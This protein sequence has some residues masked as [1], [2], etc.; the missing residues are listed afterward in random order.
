VSVGAATRESTTATHVARRIG[1]WAGFT[2]SFFSI[3]GVASASG[4]YNPTSFGWTALALS[5]VVIVAVALRAPTWRRLDIAWSGL[6]A[7]FCVFL[8]ASAGWAASAD[9]AVNDALRCVVYVVGI[10]AALV[11]L[12]RSTEHW[13][14]GLALGA[15]SVCV[16]ALAT[17]LF[18]GRFG[19]FN[20][21]STYRLFVPLGYW[22]A[23]GC[24]AAIASLI[25]LGIGVLGRE[26]PLRIAAAVSLVP[27]IATLYFTF[28]RGAWGSL[29]VGVAATFAVSPL[30]LRLLGGAAALIP[31]PA[32]GVLIASRSS[33]LTHHLVPLGAA[34]HAG[35]K[36]A[37]ELA[38][39]GVG[40]LLVAWAFVSFS[41]RVEL[42]PQLR[43]LL[44]AVVLLVIVASVIAVFTR[45]G[46]PETLATRSY[47]SFAKS[48][49]DTGSLNG[50]LFTLSNN[51][52]IVL[53]HAAVAD[54][55]AHPIIGSGAGS[56]G[57]WWLAHRTSDYFVLDA[58]ELYLQT[59]AEDGVVGLGL[60]IA[61]LAVPFV[62]G[63]RARR[64]PLVAPAVGA[65]VA[66]LAHATVDWDWQM[67]AVTLLVFFV[68]AAL[69]AASRTPT[70]QPSPASGR[71]RIAIGVAAAV[72][73]VIAFVG[74]I[75]N[76]ALARSEDDLLNAEP[77][78]AL[79]QA[80][81]AHRWAPW[82][83][84]ALRDLGESRLLVGQRGAGLSDL[85]RAA[86]KDPSDWETWLDIAA[87][88]TGAERRAA[89]ARAHALNPADPAVTA[90]ARGGPPP[91]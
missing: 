2:V 70:L 79:A 11:V 20:A 56:F 5:W 27:L 44:G 54:F 42:S 67:P 87:A 28:S 35:H 78:A 72:V 17:K 12:R 3:V 30:R 45:Y 83:A 1:P 88:G 40:Q 80:R 68:G 52:R 62:A 66:Y 75:G 89:L 86:T 77:A 29:A 24:F 7:A 51:N 37:L 39:L 23:L 8:F 4:G 34:A 59:L 31:L 16:Y 13:L 18:P 60:L 41:R 91:P 74:L 38:L 69:V 14:A 76:L 32:I 63:L 73:A 55:R 6:A 36:F 90:V 26:R 10:A 65:F 43:R 22:N 49:T 53:W 19:N 9:S 21:N 50:R 61:F 71:V 64:R 81:T 15:A 46:S 57:R 85:R 25:A 82:S 84:T 58:H 33:A 48:S 47:H